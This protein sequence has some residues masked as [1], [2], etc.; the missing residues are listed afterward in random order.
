MPANDRWDLIQRLKVK[1][2]HWLVPQSKVIQ[3]L[4]FSL[5]SG[6]KFMW[7]FVQT[8][9][10][11]VQPSLSHHRL[12]QYLC[13]TL[14]TW[15]SPQSITWACNKSWLYTSSHMVKVVLPCPSYENK[16]VDRRFSS[17]DSCLGTGGSQWSDSWS[18]HFT[19]GEKKPPRT[20]QIGD[21]GAPE[22]VWT[23]WRRGKCVF[24]FRNQTVDNTKTFNMCVSNKK[25]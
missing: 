20:H 1:Y 8:W 4:G 16:E 13:S 25:H 7:W 12:I 14:R 17:T 19:H 5:R 10:V 3:T 23:F 2:T 18:S 9:A 15:R 6:G 24:P 21:S 22:P 11:S